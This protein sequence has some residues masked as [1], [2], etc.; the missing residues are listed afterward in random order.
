MASKTAK[1]AALPALLGFASVRVYAISE[2][3]TEE[4]LSPQE[5]S[6]YAP[7]PPQLRYVEEDAGLL[8]SGLGVVRVG[9]LPYIRAIKKACVTIK[10]GA[11]NLYHAGHD[12]YEYLKDPPP[13][14]LPRVS[15]ITVSGLAGL[16][17]ARKGTRL[18]RVGVPLGLATVGTAV[19]YPVQTV[20]V[21]KLTGKQAYAATQWASSSVTSLWKP[22]PAKE[23][24]IPS[25][26]PEA[27]PVPSPEPEVPATKPVPEAEP[28]PPPA[29][30]PTLSPHPPDET[31]TIPAPEGDTVPPPPESALPEEAA[32]VP[33]PE[34]QPSPDP[35]PSP[36]LASPEPLAEPPVESS[37]PP[38][39]PVETPTPVEPPVETPTPVEPPVETPTPVEP[40]VETPAPVE[41][42]V[43]TSSPA[44]TPVEPSSPPPEP[45]V[46]TSAPAEPPVEPPVETAPPAELPLETPTEQNVPPTDPLL[47]PA[48]PPSV[49]EPALQAPLP[50][51]ETAPLLAASDP[52]PASAP[53][54]QPAS[55]PSEADPAPLEPAADT[56]V[57]EKP[58]FAPDP[59][60]LDHGQSSPEDADLYSTR[61]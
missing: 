47:V 11:V 34:V 5:L 23:V 19:C 39:P 36:E 59:K 54:E 28:A 51:E 42:S 43:E 56:E 32:P 37:P 8:Q 29:D 53:V 2:A 17:L 60:L 55:P 4:P 35:E 40:P 50:V 18:K 16:I 31:P 25:A 46:E 12:T 14:F 24:I 6:V 9:L 15:V 30:E 22:S 41:P 49:E 57:A 33:T 21:L 13:G 1:L 7:L 58:R 38:E 3:K 61:S 26:S 10:V 48:P 44:E 20:G 45:P 52:A 27:I